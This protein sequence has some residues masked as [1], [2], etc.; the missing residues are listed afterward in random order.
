[1]SE[2]KEFTDRAVGFLALHKGS[3]ERGAVELRGG[4]FQEAHFR[5]RWLN[6]CGLVG[7]LT[8]NY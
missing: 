3:F 5:G 7:Y 2:A 4:V 6:C 1:M 8:A